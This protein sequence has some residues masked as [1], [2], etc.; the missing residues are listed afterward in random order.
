MG[1]F[2]NRHPVGLASSAAVMSL[3]ARGGGRCGV[4][5]TT[6]NGSTESARPWTTCSHHSMVVPMTE[7]PDDEVEAA[8]RALSGYSHE[9]YARWQLTSKGQRW[10]DM[11]RAVLA[12]VRPRWEKQLADLRSENER[13]T[14]LVDRQLGDCIGCVSEPDET[15]P[16]HGRNYG[17]WVEIASEVI[18]HHAI[19]AERDA[20]RAELERVRAQLAE[21]LT[22]VAQ[23]TAAL[24]VNPAGCA[25]SDAIRADVATALRPVPEQEQP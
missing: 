5:I 24:R 3:P 17:E 10:N 8:A 2:A 4:P 1:M 20:A 11:A 22:V 9:Q 7:I 19:E 12:A 14:R 18:G 15:C 13:L 21:I 25:L 16:R 23:A 6:R